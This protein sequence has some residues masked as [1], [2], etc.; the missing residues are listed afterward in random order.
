[1]MVKLKYFFLVLLALLCTS[2]ASQ[3]YQLKLAFAT[4]GYHFTW[5]ETPSPIWG[6]ITNLKPLFKTQFFDSFTNAMQWKES[7]FQ[8]FQTLAS[9]Q[10][11]QLPIDIHIEKNPQNSKLV[12]NHAFGELPL[13]IKFSNPKDAQFV[14]AHFLKRRYTPSLY[15][16]AILFTR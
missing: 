11:S 14:K 15:G 6:K 3:V 7:Y 1:M 8:E 5:I 4:D 12:W 10:I 13:K 2:G 9:N 16:H